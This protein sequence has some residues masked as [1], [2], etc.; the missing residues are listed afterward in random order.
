MN[1]IYSPPDK[2]YDSEED[3]KLVFLAGPIFGTNDWQKQATDVLYRLNPQIAIANPRCDEIMHL[4]N[5][6][7]NWAIHVEWAT[8]HL[9]LS[10]AFG[11]I[12]FWLAPQTE[13]YCEKPFAQ[14]TR[15]ELAEWITHYKYRKIHAPER[16]LN[17]VLGIHDDFPGRDYIVHR[18]F[19]DCREFVIATT[20][21]ET[22]QLM[23]DKLK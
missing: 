8:A 4:N 5:E 22:C 9:R 10:S 7:E 21:E 20:L 1:K 13:H 17:I 2:W 3:L 15:F 6:D 12:M 14:T 19:N 18:V 11:G 16:P 23:T